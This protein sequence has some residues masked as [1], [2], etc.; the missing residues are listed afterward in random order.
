MWLS[1]VERCVRDAKAAG[2]NPVIPTSINNQPIGISTFQWV[3]CCFAFPPP[4][5]IVW[6][7]TLC[8][9]IPCITSQPARDFLNVQKTTYSSPKTENSIHKIPFQEEK[10]TWV[11]FSTITLYYLAFFFWFISNLFVPIQIWLASNLQLLALTPHSSMPPAKNFCFSVLFFIKKKKNVP[12]KQ[13][14]YS[15]IRVQRQSLF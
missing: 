1:L 7:D 9:E 10:P 11:G 14:T 4:F 2:S 5:D 13:T 15:V 3:F 12:E 8:S 6:D